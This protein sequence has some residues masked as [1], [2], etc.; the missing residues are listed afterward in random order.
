MTN[1]NNE[2]KSQ[3]ET[4]TNSQKQVSD[5]DTDHEND[6]PIS[7]DPPPNNVLPSYAAAATRTLTQEQAEEEERRAHEEFMHEQLKQDF[8]DEISA[9]EE[10]QL[11]DP[12]YPNDYDSDDEEIEDGFYIGFLIKTLVRTEQVKSN[13]NLRTG[14]N[15]TSTTRNVETNLAYLATGN[16]ILQPVRITGRISED[17]DPKKRPY[18]LFSIDVAKIN[19]SSHSIDAKDMVMLNS[20]NQLSRFNHPN[21]LVAFPRLTGKISKNSNGSLNITPFELVKSNKTKENWKRNN[22]TELPFDSN[23]PSH[24][25]FMVGDEVSFLLAMGMNGPVAIRVNHAIMV[26]PASK[27]SFEHG[28]NVITTEALCSYTG[29]FKNP[30]FTSG[31]TELDTAQSTEILNQLELEDTE[32][33]VHLI[34]TTSRNGNDPWHITFC[35][36]MT[37]S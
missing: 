36:V 37:T 30:Y 21:Q 19:K 5:E 4:E 28:A 23:L 8:Y 15:N 2:E 31:H 13:R 11:Q 22:N 12:Q 27:K 9:A 7:S 16:G 35:D 29:T 14:I 6:P 32:N 25:S 1:S 17:K 18:H 33:A 24:S 34:P 3:N 20:T 10:A 26:D